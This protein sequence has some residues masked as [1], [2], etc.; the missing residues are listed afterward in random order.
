VDEK[1]QNILKVDQDQEILI[2][3]ATQ[4]V[5]IGRWLLAKCNVVDA[6]NWECKE[7]FVGDSAH[8]FEM[9]RGHLTKSLTGGYP[10]N[11]YQSSVTGRRLAVQYHVLSPAAAQS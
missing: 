3:T 8:V 11:G 9:H 4:K 10:P 5:L 6:D 1:C 2:N 7:P